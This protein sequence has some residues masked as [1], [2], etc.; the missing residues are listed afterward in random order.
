MPGV[1]V[2][3]YS[4]VYAFGKLCCYMLFRDTEPKTRHW[5]SIPEELAE[6]LEKC[7]ERRVADRHLSFEPVL[8]VLQKLDP[9]HR[10][11]EEG[12]RR[13]RELVRQA[14]ERTQGQPAQADTAV[15]RALCKD[16]GIVTERA[17]AVVREE[18]QRW[19]EAEERRRA[20]E[21][22]RREQEEAERQRTEQEQAERRKREEE[23]KARREEAERQRAEQLK[24]EAEA[25][26]QEEERVRRDQE[27][28]E[29]QRQQREE[30]E[31]QRRKAELQQRANLGRWKAS[32][33]P[34]QW[35]EEHQGEWNHQDW[36][37]LVDR[38]MGS[39]YWPLNPDEMT[40]AL[41]EIKGAWARDQRGR[42]HRGKIGDVIEAPL[43]STLK[44]KLAWVPP[45]RSW[46][47]GGG[48]R[49]GTQEFTLPKGLW[50]G[51]YPVTQAEW[52]AVMGNNPSHFGGKPRHPVENVSW[53]DVQQF[54]DKLN[55][56]LARGGLTYRLPTEQEWEYICRGGPLSQSQSAFHFYF[57]RS[58]TD[59]TSAPTN[60]LSSHQANFDGTYPAGSASKGPYLQ[61]TSE[62]GLYLPNPLGVYDMHGNIW[63][64]TSS[65]E[66]SSRVFRGGCWSFI[67]EFCTASNRYGNEP[68]IR[69]LNLGFRVLAAPSERR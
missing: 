26:R 44:L 36:L 63:E 57:A 8:A 4:D 40:A 45:G 48:D 50:C 61:T 62:V 49:S 11:S 47:G 9:A 27:E 32:G 39:E 1:K 64:W 15:A 19:R 21:R 55:A 43:T 12:E 22:Q 68:G 20:T 38:V 30:A 51:V 2:G 5:K 53:D 35:V 58:K 67:A 56:R 41:E 42:L 46:L 33:E 17:N 7:S 25:K 37:V 14:L 59:L 13:L 31:K 66:G 29:R 6:M 24:R 65:Q 69:N 10:K 16:Y 52:Q 18:R 60:D 3:P 28:A 54:L 23:E 34:R